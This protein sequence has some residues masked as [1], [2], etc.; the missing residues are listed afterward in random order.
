MGIATGDYQNNGL[1]D[2]YNTTFSDD[3]NPLYRNDGD[4]NFT[5]IS[6]QMASPE[7]TIPFL[8]WGTAFF[9]YDNDGWKDLIVANGHVY[10]AVDRMPWGT[11]WAQTAAA[12]SHV[13]GKQFDLVRQ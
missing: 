5:D 8:G 9:D 3:Y 4:A 13:G 7:P 11:T 12:L 1:I 2:I 10:P 6:Y